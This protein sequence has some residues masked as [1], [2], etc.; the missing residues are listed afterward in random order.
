MRRKILVPTDF[1]KNAWFALKYATRL[2]IDDECDFYL[3]NVFSASK[4]LVESL[5]TM[6]KG[7]ESYE[8][9]KAAS[10]K[11]LNKIIGLLK[12]SEPEDIKHT[13]HVIASFNDVIEAMKDIIEQKDIELVVM[14]TKGETNN[15]KAVYGSTAIYAMEKVRNCPV[16]AIPEDASYSLPKE[17]VFPADFV[18]GYK[19]RELQYLTDIAKKCNANIAVL[20][21]SDKELNT[22]QKEQKEL[23]EEIFQ[24]N[25]YSFHFLPLHAINDAVSIFIESRESDMIAFIN[26]KH[27]FFGSVF[28]NPLVKEVTFL[29]VPVLVLHDLKN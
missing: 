29:R 21:I 27:S 6:V 22:Q 5:F 18:S 19:R 9:A 8:T 17:I 4:N 15:P 20:H 23:L 1:S 3:L 25:S 14:G 24:E 12:V 11:E 13:Y 28:T 2:Y 7:S 16:L 10:E 26:K